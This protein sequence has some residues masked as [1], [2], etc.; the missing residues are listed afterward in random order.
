MNKELE[1]IQY[2][3][4]IKKE[5]TEKNGYL[6]LAAESVVAYFISDKTEK[7]NKLNALLITI[8]S[9]TLITACGGG[10]GSAGSTG[11]GTAGGTSTGA[12]WPDRNRCLG[13]RAQRA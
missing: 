11:A 1:A 4:L 5:E 12:E 2:A 13:D 6:Y 9:A 10:G 7:I 3:N 8:A